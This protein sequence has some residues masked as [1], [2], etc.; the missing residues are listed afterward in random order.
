MTEQ[1][2]D[3]VASPAIILVRPQL[4][5]NIGT[6]ARA[7][8]N[9]GLQE[10]RLVAPRDGWPNPGVTKA[11]SG[12]DDVVNGATVFADTASAIAD[13]HFLAATT[14]RPRDMAKPVLAP[15]ELASEFK[16]RL[17]AGERCGVLFGREQSGLDNDDVALADAIVM[18]PVNPQFA[19]LNLAQA[20]LLIA[21]EWQK[22]RADQSL[23]RKT[24]F[25][26]L[27]S[28]GPQHRKSRPAVKSELIGFFEQLERE[29]DLSG[30]LRPPEKRPVMVRNIRNMFERMGATEQEVRTLRGIV[31]SLTRAHRSS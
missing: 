17:S 1:A 31:A 6:T 21:Y 26:G 16:N 23:G 20:V 9:F 14:A 18:A 11:A 29:L 27:V 2:H 30:F 28:T 19:S 8:A 4:G 7:M 10:L 15:E 3:E 25:D 5:E 12:A 24:E 22:V 13:L